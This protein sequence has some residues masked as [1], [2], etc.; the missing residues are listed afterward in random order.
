MKNKQYVSRLLPYSV[1]ESAAEGDAEAVNIVLNH[2]K[3][4]IAKLSLVG[5]KD[6]DGNTCVYADDELRRRLETKLIAKILTFQ[7]DR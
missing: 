5:G 3:G 1:I 2:Y 7:V 6:P 4:Y